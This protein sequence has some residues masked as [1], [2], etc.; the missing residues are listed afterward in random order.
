M[1]LNLTNSF[2]I[3]VVIGACLN[4]KHEMVS[5]DLTGFRHGIS[6]G[7]V[8]CMSVCSSNVRKLGNWIDDSRLFS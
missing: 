3:R 8:M 2:Q 6:Y 5:V 7:D 4:N 1:V